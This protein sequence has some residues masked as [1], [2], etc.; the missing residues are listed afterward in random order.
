MTA[1]DD[2]S[3]AWNGERG[4]IDAAMLARHLDGVRNPIF[5]I[6]GPSGMVQAS[7]AMLAASGADE[8]DVRTEEFTGY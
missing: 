7:R 8:D 3:P 1:G 4:H 5:Y 6:A 2:S